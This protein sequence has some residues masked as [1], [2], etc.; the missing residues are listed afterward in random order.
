MKLRTLRFIRPNIRWM[1]RA[2]REDS[3]CCNSRHAARCCRTF[4]HGAKRTPRRIAATRACPAPRGSERFSLPRVV[5]LGSD[6]TVL[7][8]PSTIG[9]RPKGTSTDPQTRPVGITGRLPRNQSMNPSKQDISSAWE[10]FV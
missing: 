2:I 6:R 8:Y 4:V 9:A 7:A 5:D 3:G 1:T 10:V